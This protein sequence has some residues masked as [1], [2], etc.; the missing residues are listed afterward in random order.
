MGVDA[1]AGLVDSC[2]GWLEFDS[3]VSSISRLTVWQ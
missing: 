1:L 2:R 3:E